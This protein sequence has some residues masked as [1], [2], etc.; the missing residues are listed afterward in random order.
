MTKKTTTCVSACNSVKNVTLSSSIGGLVGELAS[1]PFAFTLATSQPMTGAILLIG[2][3]G[4]MTLGAG[5][6][7]TYEAGKLCYS[8]FFSKNEQNVNTEKRE[9]YQTL[10]AKN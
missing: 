4:G 9:N 3:F 5:L 8:R 6:G 10:N 1:V 7:V 2:M